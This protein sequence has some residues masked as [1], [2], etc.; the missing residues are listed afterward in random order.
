[1]PALIWARVGWA[2]CVAFIVG[3][4]LAMATIA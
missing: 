1:L 4:Q 2:G 3:V